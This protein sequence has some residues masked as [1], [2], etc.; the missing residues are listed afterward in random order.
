[1]HKPELKKDKTSGLSLEVRK[2]IL[3]TLLICLS[4]ITLLAGFKKAGPA[5]DIFYSIFSYLFGKGYY[6]ISVGLFIAGIAIAISRTGKVFG[7]NIIW[8]VLLLTLSLLGILD[9]FSPQA[10]GKVGAVIGILE[11]PFE[12]FASA[13]IIFTLMIISTL[14][15]FNFPLKIKVKIKPK[16]KVSRITKKTKPIVKISEPVSETSPASNV[17]STKITLEEP[18]PLILSSKKL[19][20]DYIPPRLDLLVTADEKPIMGNVKFNAEVIRK[21]L[22]SFGIPVEMGEI[23]VGSTVTRYTLKPAEGIKL[24]KITS[25][26]QDLALALAVSPIRIVAPIPGKS[27]VG[28]EVPN[29]AAAVVRLGILLSS[30][31][32][33]KSGPLVFP[34]GRAINGDS[35]FADITTMPHLLVAGATGS[36]KS[37]F[38]HSLIV[39]LL[40]KNSPKFLNFI[41]IDPK[42]VEFSQYQGLPHLICPVIYDGKQA[43][44]VL[45]WAIHEMEKRY[46]LL[47][48]KGVRDVEHYNLSE[49]QAIP[50]LLIIIDELADLMTAY[51]REVEGAIIRLAQMA[52]ATG[53]HLIM[54]TQRPSIEVVT[55][56]IKANITH[57]IALRVASQVDSRTIL[58]FA[59]AEKLLGRG[60]MLYIYPEV[61]K[62]KRIQ[63]AYISGE[64]IKR[65][66]KFIRE[67]NKLKPTFEL[68]PE[69]LSENHYLE[70]SEEKE[71]EL[72]PEAIEE[73]VRAK[74]A[75][76]S[77]LQRRLSIGYA[78]AARI[79]DILESKGLIGPSKGAKPREVYLDKI[80]KYQQQK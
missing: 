1:M 72:L 2:S 14:I 32:F 21:T 26:T 76:A 28:I 22:L 9:L 6:F 11:I 37:I 54:S 19:L 49:K 73:I 38:L 16:E 52:R 36:G 80:A 7:Q 24:S 45:N 48:Q 8:G 12:K 44:K 62:P 5:G 23:T 47:T 29:R 64:E 18:K 15:I 71:D 40:F 74:K 69:K 58:D 33:R 41:L 39:S 59:G 46:D 56:L 20:K 55:G 35:V 67:N 31:K 75:S 77:L 57:R 27:L 25:L 60:D 68:E 51:S 3:A 50:Y 79:L 42:R 66:V 61:S 30:Q 17:E 53:I 10:G 13:I 63:G 65:V 78:R 70:T 4:A 34:M 43:I